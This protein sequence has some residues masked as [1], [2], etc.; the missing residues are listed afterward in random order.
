MYDLIIYKDKLYSYVCQKKN[1]TSNDAS[2]NE[3][4]TYKFMRA[5]ITRGVNIL[6]SGYEY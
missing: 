6:F 2:I 1:P 5:W 3:I 4:D